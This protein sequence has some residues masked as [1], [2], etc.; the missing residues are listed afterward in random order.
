MRFLVV[1]SPHAFATRDV[2]DGHV[3]GLRKVLGEEAVRTYDVIK[4]FRLFHS[5]T[6]MIK[7]AYGEVPRG[8]R[9]NVLA[10]EPVLGAAV[11]YDCDVVII[12]SPMY[13]PMSIIETI[14]KVGKKVWGI[15]TEC[16]YEDEF[17][18]RTQAPYFDRVFVNDRNS[19]PRFSVFNPDTHYLPHA[20][21]PDKHYPRWDRPNN[22][23]HV[24]FVGTDFKSRRDLFRDANW[25]D[26]DF[27]LYGNWQ[28][29]H[30]EDTLFPYVRHRL[31][32]NH[33]TAQ[34]YRG[35]VVGISWHRQERYWDQD[36]L[37]DKGEAYSVGPRSYELAACGL[38]QI[39][40]GERQE[41]TDIFGESIP[42]FD[43]SE[44]LEREVRWALE[45][46]VERQDLARQQHE[47]VQGHT[48]ENRAELILNTT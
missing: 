33:T 11:Y 37:I 5:W 10:C 3:A 14:R 48:F 38:Y 9:A 31:I 19:I 2:Y 12:V 22:H 36:G 40:D 1:S 8:V 26:I 29:V 25:A 15:F 4:R 16:P 32:D 47:A 30:E 20:Y 13:F 41:L 6:Q 28:E 42:T 24:V 27:R 17:W 34:L 46:P 7:D 18:A 44:S 35:A 39:S 21:N 23:Q 45:H 43:S